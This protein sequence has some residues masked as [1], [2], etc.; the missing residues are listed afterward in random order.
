[1]ADTNNHTIRMGAPT[2]APLIQTQPQSQ[3]V[4]SGSSVRF[5]VTATGAPAPIFQWKKDSSAIPGATGSTYSLASALTSDAG[6]YTVVITNILGSVTSNQATL[7]VNTPAPPPSGGGG[8]GG[9][10]TIEA[11]FALV[12]VA[13]GG[14]RQARR[15]K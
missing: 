2:A 15:A 8:G 11:W 14:A 5:S 13:L 12:L 1:M 9:G 7:T 3:T 6:S 10:G 4:T